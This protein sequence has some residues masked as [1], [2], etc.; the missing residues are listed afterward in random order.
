MTYRFTTPTVS[1]ERVRVRVRVRVCKTESLTQE[2]P[3]TKG[4]KRRSV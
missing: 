3:I 4:Y 2:N 1:N